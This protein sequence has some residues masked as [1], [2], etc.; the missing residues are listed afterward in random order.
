MTELLTEITT[1]FKKKKYNFFFNGIYN[2]NIIGIR[3][4]EYVPDK[5][6]CHLAVFY[7][8]YSVDNFNHWNFHL[9]PFTTYPGVH[10]LKNP[11]NPSG[12]ALLKE[13]QY[14]SAYTIGPHFSIQSLVQHGGEVEVYRIPHKEPKIEK[15][16][17]IES[18][19]I[20]GFFG[21]NIHP[22]MDGNEETIGQSS[23]GC[24]VF[25][26]RADFDFFMGLCRHSLRYFPNRFTYT[27]I[28]RSELTTKL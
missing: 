28:N 18:T 25:Q 22:D 20:R 19:V 24:Q 9:F 12:C 21:I 2:L 5:Y 14:K 1:L 15:T 16:D 6:S 3:A 10:F 8:S 13:N 23:A 26:R 11:M 4:P 7:K 17:L 27:L